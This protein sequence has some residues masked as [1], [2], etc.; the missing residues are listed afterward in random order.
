MRTKIDP[1]LLPTPTLVNTPEFE[2]LFQQTIAIF[3]QMSPNYAYFVAADPIAQEL[4][5]FA[6]AQMHLFALLNDRAKATLLF[7]A[8]GQDLDGWGQNNLVTRMV[9]QAEDLTANPPVP[10]I[11]ESDARYRDRIQDALVAYSSAGPPE[12]YRFAAM[13][14]DVRV[15]DAVVYSPDLP[16]FLNMG[17]RVSIVILSTEQNGVPSLD[18]LSIVR[19]AVRDKGVK[20]VSDIVEVE[21]ATIRPVDIDANITLERDAPVDLLASL[22]ASLRAQFADKQV[23]GWDCPRSW[24]IRTLSPDGVYE[25]ALNTPSVTPNIKPNEFPFINSVNLRFAGLAVN[26]DWQSDVLA[27][28]ALIRQVVET[29]IS[30][31]ITAKKSMLQIQSDLIPV[32]LPGIVQPTLQNVALYLGLT[33]IYTDNTQTTMLPSDEVALM[34]HYKLSAYYERG[35]YA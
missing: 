27:A 2:T 32:Q 22:E 28:Q 16:N 31:V 13:S 19:T 7:F 3:M 35:Y 30:Y 34:I 17:G 29:Y 8:S 18:L 33:G 10:L 12:H 26:E 25:T 9:V 20:V 14:A 1:A 5:C 4:R 15:K 6:L 24:I 23:L 21:P 11:M